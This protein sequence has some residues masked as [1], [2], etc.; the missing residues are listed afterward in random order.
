VDK[1]Y[2]SSYHFSL[3]SPEMYIP[4]QYV[5][6]NHARNLK[7]LT[8]TVDSISFKSTHTGTLKATDGVLAVCS[9]MAVINIQQTLINI[10]I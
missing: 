4:T 5:C 2:N 8:G 7:T 1:R 10:Y 9:W 6:I 3:Y